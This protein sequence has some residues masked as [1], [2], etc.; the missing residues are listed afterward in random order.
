MNELT[1]KPSGAV[2]LPDNDQWCGR[3]QIRSSSSNRL[4]IIAKN[5]KTGRYGC[6]CPAYR[7]RRYCKHLT[8][9]CGL[10]LSEIHG[11]G[12]IEQRPS[13]KKLK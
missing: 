5:K 6:S 1:I 10:S 12:A 9:G 11:N 4:Y 8:S 2:S 7:T 13:Q 3:F